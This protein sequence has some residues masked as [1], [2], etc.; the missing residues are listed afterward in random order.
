MKIIKSFVDFDKEKKQEMITKINIPKICNTLIIN[1]TKQYSGNLDSFFSFSN[2]IS[3]N[4]GSDNNILKLN[5]MSSSSFDNCNN[6]IKKGI[7]IS[8]T[9]GFNLSQ[10]DEIKEK[11][12]E[13]SNIEYK[14]FQKLIANKSLLHYNSGQKIYNNRF[15]F[16]FYVFDN[17]NYI[18][19]YNIYKIYNI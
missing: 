4:S 14:N 3:Q 13:S 18:Q 5:H 19:N 16:K 8:K 6:D 11:N 7:K 1:K 10:K 15:L 17:L 2:N 9:M 12:I